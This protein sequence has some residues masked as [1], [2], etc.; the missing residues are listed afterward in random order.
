[1]MLKKI[2]HLFLLILFNLSFFAQDYSWQ[3]SGLPLSTGQL[4]DCEYS[5]S[6][7]ILYATGAFVEQ[8]TVEWTNT[9]YQLATY[10]NGT[11]TYDS[12]FN[13]QPRN[14]TTFDGKILITG[15]FN[16]HHGIQSKVYQPYGEPIF[17]DVI[18]VPESGFMWLKV[19]N[20]TIFAIGSFVELNGV[21]VNGL[22]KWNGSSWEPVPPFNT[23]EGPIQLADIEYYQGEYYVSGNFTDSEIG[24]QKLAV[25]RDGALEQV[26]IGFQ[27]SGGVGNLIV[28]QDE[29]IITGMIFKNAGN[30]GNMIMKWNGEELLSIGADLKDYYNTYIDNAQVTNVKIINDKLYICG[31]FSYAG[32]I[33][34]KGNVVWDG[35]KFCSLGG[36]SQ[37]NVTC[38]AQ[39]GDTIVLGNIEQNDDVILNKLAFYTGYSDVCSTVNV[40][41][42][43]VNDKLELLVYPNPSSSSFN[44]QFTEPQSNVVIELYDNKGK[45]VLT[46]NLGDI[47]KGQE[48]ELN[49]KQF[50]SG[51]YYILIRNGTTTLYTTKM[52][53]Q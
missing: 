23:F 37:G 44:L 48:V 7:N 22:A 43:E 12:D 28:Y 46:K 36:Y 15:S 25:I 13:D 18:S 9:W 5:A 38:F 24:P 17:P 2:I 20:D 47:S 14:I 39:M 34:S 26:G 31:V 49:V 52:I 8:D 53:K 40:D 32:D 50:E 35:E 16:E 4:F 33:Q 6:E 10:N 45:L 41:E 11:W 29:L 42:Y 30:P 1:M 21:L 51:I 19:T 27:G 3:S